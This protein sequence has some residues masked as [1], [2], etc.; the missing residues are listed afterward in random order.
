VQFIVF[1]VRDSALGQFREDIE[2]DIR[3]WGAPGNMQ[4]NRNN[5][6]DCPNPGHLS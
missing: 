3:I 1:D 4:V 5:L 2:D 6:M